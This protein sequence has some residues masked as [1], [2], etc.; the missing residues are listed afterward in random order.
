MSTENNP[1]SRDL[2]VS[3]LLEAAIKISLLA[4]LLIWCFQIIKPFISLILWGGILAIALYPVFTWLKKRFARGNLLTA[5]MIAV[6][7]LLLII[8][9]MI[10]IS[11]SL[12]ETTANLVDKYEQGQL[13]VPPPSQRIADLPLL[14][15]K[16]YDIWNQFA[17][18]ATE[19]AKN[20]QP[21]IKSL[22]K[23]LLT[24]SAN[25]GMTTL[26]F[27]TSVI[28]AAFLMTQAVVIRSFF[29]KVFSRINK[30]G[31]DDLVGLSIGTIRS[32][33]QGV[34]GIAFIQALLA[35]PAL[36]LMGI[37]AAGLLIL[38]ILLLAII[39]VP[40]SL[41]IFPVIAYAY[42]IGDATYATIF[43]IW[44]VL[45][46]LSD[47]VLKPIM[48]GRGVNVPMLIILLG[49]LGGMLMSGIIGLF[50]GAVV[51]ALGYTLFIAWVNTEDEPAVSGD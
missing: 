33:A 38:G 39:Q 5:S 37:P 8:V 30:Q 34:I 26:L 36:L 20:F 14:G 41:I 21:Q 7:L 12:I 3:S 43:A 11:E 48:L 15:D 13:V 24:L 4:L 35:A 23:W 44:M 49:A 45:V 47:N 17:V 22:G 46:G 2:L 40:T 27:M 9:P 31:G 32:V 51:L 28:L 25:M 50:T 16:V 19:A 18:N 29:V 6:P 42:S 10:F 1:G